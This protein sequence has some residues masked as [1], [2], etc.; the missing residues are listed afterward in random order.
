MRGLNSTPTIKKFWGYS[1]IFQ[2]SPKSF[3]NYLLP[4]KSQFT[5]KKAER[6]LPHSAFLL[7][8]EFCQHE[9]DSNR[10]QYNDEGNADHKLFVLCFVSDCEH[11]KEHRNRAAE[12][13]PHKESRLGNSALAR[14]CD[15][16]IVNRNDD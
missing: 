6:D 5:H 11:C 8:Y 9:I 1:G 3:L 16:L 7:K 10:L 15:S 13:G 12:R 4:D 2:N 14:S